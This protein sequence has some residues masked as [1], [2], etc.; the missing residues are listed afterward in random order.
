MPKGVRHGEERHVVHSL[1]L[2]KSLSEIHRLIQSPLPF[3]RLRDELFLARSDGCRRTLPLRE[4]RGD[5]SLGAASSSPAGGSP[6]FQTQ[7]VNTT[8]GLKTNNN[9]KKSAR[10]NNFYAGLETFSKTETHK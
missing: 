4:M 9:K 1:S 8:G 6:S 5:G 3:P 7:R 2:E 10:K